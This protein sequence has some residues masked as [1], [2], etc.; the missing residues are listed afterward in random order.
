MC[1]PHPLPGTVLICL[2]T[3]HLGGGKDHLPRVSWDGSVFSHQ[4]RGG[5]GV[6]MTGEEGL[7]WSLP[8]TDWPPVAH[9]LELIEEDLFI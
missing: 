3:I 4:E 2:P 9:R 6:G 1:T 8:K 7:G 5:E